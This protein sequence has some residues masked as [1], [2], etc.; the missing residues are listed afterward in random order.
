MPTLVKT[1]KGRVMRHDEHRDQSIE[2][3][4]RRHYRRRRVGAANGQSKVT[5]GPGE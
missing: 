2:A 3:R 4:Q 1:A 5:L